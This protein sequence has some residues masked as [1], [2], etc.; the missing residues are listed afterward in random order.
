[1]TDIVTT[2]TITNPFGNVVDADEVG[3]LEETV[4]DTMGTALTAGTNIT[5][6]PDDAN[7]TITIAAAGAG[8][9]PSDQTDW[10]GETGST[11]V[12]TTTVTNIADSVT[13]VVI[14]V[15]SA[16]VTNAGA[17]TAGTGV[18]LDDGNRQSDGTFDRASGTWTGNEDVPNA[19]VYVGITASDFSGLTLA[20]NFLEARRGGEL[21]YSSSLA[22]LTT[23][24]QLSTSQLEY[25][26]TDNDEYNYVSGDVLTV[27][28]RSTTS[29]TLYNY[30]N[31]DFTSNV[32]DLPLNAVD[33]DFEARVVGASENL[34][35]SVL[36]Q[37]KLDGL[38][39]TSS[40]QTGQTLTVLYKEGAP[41][42][43]VSDYTDTWDASNPLLASFTEQRIVS[44]LVD[45]NEVPTDIAG[46]G[47]ISDPIVLGDQRV[48]QVTLPVETGG[49]T[50]T[51][52]TVTG[53]ITTVTPS[54]FSTDYKI[55]RD[56]LS[57]ALQTAIDNG[58]PDSGAD[59]ALLQSL[60]SKV[61]ALYPLTP[62]VGDLD[63]WADIYEPE[64]PVTEVREQQGYSLF[65]DYRGDATRYESTG[66]TYD[67]T[68]TN[69]VRYTGLGNNAYRTFGFKVAGPS[70]QVLLWLVDGSE[71]IP[72]VDMTAAGNFRINNYTI[73][74]TAGTP[75]SNRLTLVNRASGNQLVTQASGNSGYNIPDFPTGATDTSRSAE[76]EATIYVSGTNTLAGGVISFPI[77]NTQ[78]AQD[79]VQ[80]TH[81]FDL[82]PLHGNR[83]V[84][85]T[86]DYR[87]VIT[88]DPFY[89]LI[90]T[91][92]TAPSD[93]SVDFGQLELIESF[94]PTDT[95]TRTDDFQTF[96]GSL[97]DY[98][99]T[100]E[101]ELL[102]TFH[103]LGTTASTQ[104][105]AVAIGATGEAS[106]FND[107][108]TPRPE[109]GLSAVEIPDQTALSGF[110]F[111]TFAPEHYL[112]H[113]DLA[114]LIE[115]RA[116]QWAYG[117]ARAV[118]ISTINAI[119]E[120][121]DLASGS[122]L[123]GAAF[124]T[125][126]EIVSVY[127]A[128]GTGTS[129]GELVSSV[130][131][132][133]N[134]ADFD[135]VHV[136]EYDSSSSQWRHAAFKASILALADTNDNIRLQG[137]TVLQ[138]TLASRTLAMNPTAQEIFSI[139]LVSI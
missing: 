45:A 115:D 36:N 16:I 68:G 46:G 137:N 101:N 35:L 100:G 1:M 86:F 38:T 69:V 132:P 23:P 77:P 71:L 74:H 125:G 96:Q 129:S 73:A 102:L 76:F 92:V 82:G 4:R 109:V 88:A 75:V 67:A 136:T 81:T 89:R 10:L 29:A 33:A 72:Y 28:T 120:P 112:R 133:A 27:V 61:A 84:T 124:A 116:T 51:T 59:H 15:R 31:G 56:N 83:Q 63:D 135:Y 5:I 114:H 60:D 42:G 127:E 19:Y 117:L 128:T 104:A 12:S 85:V 54:G 99:F 79:R 119:T 121:V 7:D 126:G 57:T 43:K 98:T 18:R 48:Y 39:A 50:A 130:I 97:G 30:G 34:G 14:W 138:W 9:L 87:F 64:R 108:R 13:D 2:G 78:T 8:G 55:V 134:Y 53:T 11:Q 139:E 118:T 17:N 95:V 123:N 113:S 21:V 70:N 110:E 66:V 105:V 3:N 22:D 25:R 122:T 65:A 103:P 52:Y 26:R 20:D 111:R 41:S 58:S 37:G 47:D 94:T 91:V 24:T 131:L 62:N 80:L 32:D 107:I 49:S 93:I 40:E 106:E 44:I 90:M 6:T